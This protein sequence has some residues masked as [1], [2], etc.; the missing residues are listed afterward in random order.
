[1]REA[2]VDHETIQRMKI[3][4]FIF[5]FSFKKIRVIGMFLVE[6]SLGTKNGK[7]FIMMKKMRNVERW[8]FFNLNHIFMLLGVFVLV[9]NKMNK[10][11]YEYFRLFVSKEEHFDKVL[12]CL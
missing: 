6:F 5:Y 1:M 11:F 9:R 3:I 8:K 10:C 7:T 2:V 4:E 12:V